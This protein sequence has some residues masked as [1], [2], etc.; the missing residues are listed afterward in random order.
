MT[1]AEW[2]HVKQVLNAALEIPPHERAGF[3]DRETNGDT[4]LRAEVESLLASFD[5]AGAFIEAPAIAPAPLAQPESLSPGSSLGPYHIV[6]L[7][8]EGGMGAVYQAVRVDDLYRKVVAVKVIRHSVYGEYALKRF[9]TER[10]ILAHLDHPAIARLLDGGTTPDGR[11]YFVMDFIAGTPID[12]YCDARRL[13][14]AERL[15]LFLTVCSAVHYAH[16]NLVVHRDLK[17]LNILITEEG[18]LKLLDFGI[19]KLVDAEALGGDNTVTMMQPMTPEYASPEQVRGQPVTTASDV[20]SLGVLL[21]RL[22][23][24]HRLYAVESRSVEEIFD[25]VRNCEPRRPSTAIRSL[26]PDPGPGRETITL[27]P[28]LVGARRSTK[29]EKLEKQL[30]GDL[31]NILLMALRKEPLRRYSSVEQFAGDLRR[32]LEGHPVSA[33]PDTIR[34]RTGKFIRRHRTGVMAA[35][36]VILSLVAGIIGT[37]WQAHVA[38]QHRRRAEQRFNEVRGLANAVLFELHDAIVPLPGSTEARQLLVKRAQRYLDSLASESAGDE[39]LQHERAMA[40]ERIGDVLG[41]PSQP[42]LGQTAAALENYRKALSID[43]ELAGN[44]PASFTLQMDMARAYNRIC[45]IQQSTGQFRE[46]LAACRQAE[47]IQQDQAERRPTDIDLREELAGTYQNM[48]GCYSVLGDWPNAEEK[49]SRALHEFA[50]LQS[51]QP[52]HERYLFELATAYHRMAGLEEQTKRFS[53]GSRSALRAVDLFDKLSARHP[54]DIRARLDWTFAEQRLGSIMIS[55]GRL[56]QALAAFQ[57][58]LPIREQLRALDP[59]DAR[60]Q[61]NLSNSHAA[62]GVV[63]LETGDA[64]AAEVHFEQQRRLAAGLAR[65]DPV[66]VDYQYSLSEALENLGRIALRLGRAAEGRANLKEALRIYD[67]LR[68]RGAI[69][70]EYAHVPGRIQTE[71]AAALTRSR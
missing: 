8:A 63:L 11:P 34:Y 26:E 22:L 55:M 53:A 65:V 12:E 36:L 6:Q 27:T 25:N 41:L 17:P 19:A 9:D 66:R 49:L 30:A 21:Y 24:G 70:A 64:R 71:L 32:H 56:N 67:D 59:K 58:V 23:T 43:G 14:I 10:Q 62:I 38:E 7:I 39:G 35:A 20:Y 69:S 51:L 15:Q 47:A 2:Q 68:A 46:A 60:A 54:Q 52:D 37:S 13:T 42:N 31:D 4:A 57:R 45:S 50:A 3:L 33:R 1:S 28:E 40:Y 44:A 5:S 18:S 61:S 16:Q 48:A 29:P